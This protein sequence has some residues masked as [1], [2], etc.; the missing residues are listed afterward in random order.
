MKT[1]LVWDGLIKGWHQ[2]G[3]WNA[4]TGSMKRKSGT[5]IR[6]SIT[7]PSSVIVARI[8]RPSAA[9]ALYEISLR[10]IATSWRLAISPGAYRRHEHDG[11]M[12]VTGSHLFARNREWLTIGEIELEFERGHALANGQGSEPDGNAEN[13]EDGGNTYGNGRT[14]QLARLVNNLRRCRFSTEWARSRCRCQD[15][16]YRSGRLQAHCGLRRN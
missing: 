7:L 15:Q 6:S 16:R 4:D 8:W 11:A 12:R 1:T 14:L 3:W 9:T 13:L 10:S 2:R 5:S